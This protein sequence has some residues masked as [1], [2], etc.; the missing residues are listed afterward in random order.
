MTAWSSS[1]QDIE[2][3]VSKGADN[4]S[5]DQEGSRKSYHVHNSNQNENS[6]Q[7]IKENSLLYQNQNY[8]L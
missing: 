3:W 7:L 4:L 1:T 5:T 2:V 6:K 8:V